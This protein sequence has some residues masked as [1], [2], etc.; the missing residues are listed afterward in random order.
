M[1]PQD[2]QSQ[3]VR[4]F[5]AE[6]WPV[7]TIAS[8]LG[9]HHTTVARALARSG[10]PRPDAP[11]RP[12]LVDPYL[13]FILAT[14]EKYPRLRASR[15]Y[16]MVRER[17]YPGRPDHFRHLVALYR[18]RPAAEAFLRLRT[19]PGEQ[20][21]VDWGHFGK[22]Q[23]GRAQRPLYA[24]VM[25]LSYSRYLFLRFYLDMRL[26]S[27]LDGHLCA[28]ARFDGVARVLLYDNLKS[29]VTE[30][31]GDAIRFQPTLLDFAAHYLYEP[32]PVAVARGNEK[33]RVEKAIQYA[34]HSFFAARTFKDL[35][36][37]NAQANAWCDGLAADRRC[38][39]DRTLSVREAFAQEQPRLLALPGNP[40]PAHE[41]LEVSVGKTPYVRFDLNDYSVPHTRVR[42]TLVVLADTR[43]VRVVD[44][45]EVVATH[46]RSYSRAEQ[47]EDPAHLDA[48]VAHK[49]R[50]RQH[51]AMDRL[52]QAAPHSR[53]LL[54]RLAERGG[55]LGGATTALLRLLDTYGA[56]EL[57]AAIT[58][59]LAG[60]VPHP[61]AVRHVLERRRRERGLPPPLPL[62]LPDDPRVRDLVVRPHPLDSYDALN[63]KDRRHDQDPHTP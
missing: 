33:G 40:Y 15:L 34:R 13:P 39:E 38:P 24:F 26:A 5:Q 2:L 41:R 45:D 7:G 46:A 42:R 57:D 20:A 22:L 52:Q 63:P 14:L 10:V 48:L 9:V 25:V 49:R 27:F 60:D 43:Q 56:A 12:S 54:V 17:G 3:I 47:I 23:V 35:D 55:G 62:A 61:H 6:R 11:Y 4:L 51:R 37:L 18:P 50:A 59:A 44:G 58:E 32:R 28:F 21:Q 16:D 19:L 1:I 31:V 36:D 8:Q 53:D 29:A 30:R